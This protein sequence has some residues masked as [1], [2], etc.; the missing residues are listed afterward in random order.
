MKSF[1][2]SWV[3]YNSQGS[4]SDKYGNKFDSFDYYEIQAKDEEHAKL[5]GLK[6]IYQMLENE[7]I[8]SQINMWNCDVIEMKEEIDED[9]EDLD[10]LEDKL[11]YLLEKPSQN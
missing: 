7:K 11:D 4:S 2:V 9:F 3:Y 1:L 10:C 6:H 5:Q 8:L